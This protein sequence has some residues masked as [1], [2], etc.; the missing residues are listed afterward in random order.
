MTKKNKWIAATLSFIFAGAGHLYLG[1]T[2]KAIFYLFAELATVSLMYSV[3]E[4]FGAL[5]NLIVG[6]SAIA[7]SFI[8]A[9]KINK[10]NET[11][12]EVTPE[13]KKEKPVVK[14]Y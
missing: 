1:K 3:H 8:E 11:K 6:V 4:E 7:D 2:K 12:K 13:I 10:Q 5:L 9:K 14:V